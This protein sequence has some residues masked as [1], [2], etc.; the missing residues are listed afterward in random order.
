MTLKNAKIGCTVH[1][2]LL[3][4]LEVKKILI[5]QQTTWVT[6]GFN[7]RQSHTASVSRTKHFVL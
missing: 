3:T 5:F 6:S 1:L 4:G 2:V 7:I